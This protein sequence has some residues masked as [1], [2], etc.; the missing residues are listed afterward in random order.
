MSTSALEPASRLLATGSLWGAI[1]GL[2]LAAALGRFLGLWGVLVGPLLAGGLITWSLASKAR[3]AHTLL[4]GAA[5]SAMAL[6]VL[7]VLA[8]FGSSVATAW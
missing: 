7:T 8:M 3:S 4:L 1:V 6:I 2:F 5:G